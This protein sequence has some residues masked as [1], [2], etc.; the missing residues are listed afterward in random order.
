MQQMT[1][2][3]ARRQGGEPKI[4]IG[5]S[6]GEVS[7]DGNDIFGMSVIEAARLCA[8]AAPG[9]ILV[10]DLLRL[11]TRGL[12][13][14]FVAA[15]EFTLK[16][17]PEPVR[18]YNLV[19]TPQD[20]AIPLPPKIPRIPPFGLYGRANEQRTIKSCWALSKQGQ[21]QMVVLAGEPGIGKTRLAMEVGR[22]VHAEGGIVLFG[23]CDEDIGYPYR[24]LAEALQHYVANA[25]DDVLL[26]HVHEHQDNLLRIVPALAHRVPNISKQ[27]TVAEDERF[28]MFE[29]VTGLLSLASQQRPVLLILDD[30]QW[31]GARN[32]CC[33]SIFYARR[34]R[35]N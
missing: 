34:S 6:C 10:S 21:R 14:Q 11:L 28:W 31:A 25:P 24:M 4:R 9:Q 16:G 13:H 29:A 7:H 22:S 19:W 23:S 30:L 8:A 35:C 18:A 33:S 27:V 12:E 32:C 5:A 2:A 20:D 3:T 17:F 1:D 26:Q 15:G